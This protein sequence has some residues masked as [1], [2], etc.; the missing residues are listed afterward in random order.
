MLPIYFIFVI[1]RHLKNKSLLT[2]QQNKK[3]S[4]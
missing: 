2:Q 1:L 3:F 4:L